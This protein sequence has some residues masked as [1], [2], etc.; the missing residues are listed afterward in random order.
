MKNNSD[1]NKRKTL[2]IIKYIIN[3]IVYSKFIQFCKSSQLH[4]ITMT[5]PNSNIYKITAK[6]MR[7]P[8]LIETEI[9]FWQFFYGMSLI[10]LKAIGEKQRKR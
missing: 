2:K 9:Q 4:P 10:E 6:K 1:N 8:N 3:K 7:E 5:I